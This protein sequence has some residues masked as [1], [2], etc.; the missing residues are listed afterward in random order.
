[1]ADVQRFL[2]EDQAQLNELAEVYGHRTI[3]L[4]EYLAARK[5]IQQRID[6]ARRQVAKVTQTGALDRYVGSASVLRDGWAE[7]PIS[8]RRAIIAAVL[9]HVVVSPAVRGRT[10]FDPARVAPLWRI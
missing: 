2:A 4:G 3:S 8:R 5:P 9:D 1:M 6:I 7:L 10:A